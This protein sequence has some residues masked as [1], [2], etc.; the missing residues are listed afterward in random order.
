MRSVLLLTAA[1]VVLAA[2]AWSLI[3]AWR[4][5]SGSPE[6]T[7]EL[8]EREL[9]MAEMPWEST[10]TLL[11][12]RWDVLSDPPREH[13]P[14]AWLDAAKLA[15]IGFDCTIPLSS[16]NAKEHYASMPSMLAYLVL[17][18]EGDAWRQASRDRKPKTR[19]FVVDAGSD[20]R[21]LRDRYPDAKRHVVVRG[22]VRLSYQDRSFPDGTLLATP[23]LQGWIA[24]VLPSQVF[25]PRPHNRHLEALRHRGPPTEQPDGEAPRFAVTV[26]WGSNHEPWVRGVRPLV[27]QSPGQ[28]PL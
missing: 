18:Y 27:P 22:V 8:T 28:K 20:A 16:K 5:R 9:R 4:N 23:R 12:L 3:A 14:P 7:V 25:V 15:E 1:V 19:L 10:A 17:E 2:N 26:S 13:G 11:E 21:L 24:N 6:S